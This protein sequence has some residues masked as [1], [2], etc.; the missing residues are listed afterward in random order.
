MTNEVN[1]KRNERL[2]AILREG[3]RNTGGDYAWVAEYLGCSTTAVSNMFEGRNRPKME[4]L[5]LLA[6]ALE[7]DYE[8]L[9]KVWRHK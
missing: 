2:G 7:I 5:P 9:I 8:T 1:L 4:K 6:Y 3:L